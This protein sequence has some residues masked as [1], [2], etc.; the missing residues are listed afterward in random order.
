MSTDFI[1]Q[2]RDFSD[3]ELDIKHFDDP[4]LEVKR[5]YSIAQKNEIKDHDAMVLSTMKKNNFPDSRV[6]LIRQF[7]KDGFI[8]FT[9]Y[10]SNKGAQ[11]DNNNKVSLNFYWSDIDRQI[12]ILGVAEKISDVSSLAYFASRPRASQ[13]GAWASLQSEELKT[14]EDLLNRVKEFEIKFKDKDVPKPNHWGGYLVKPIEIEFWKGQPSR[15]HHRV[16]F[17]K[18]SNDNWENKRLNP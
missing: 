12:R 1:T 8:F 7:I 17:F 4:I 16:L 5:W 2:R 15:L 10:K 18:N 6:V 11:I 3:E 13:I 9:N 14:N